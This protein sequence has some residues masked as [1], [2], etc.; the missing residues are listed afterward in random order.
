MLKSD[1]WYIIELDYKLYIIERENGG[2][3]TMRRALTAIALDI[4][5]Q[6]CH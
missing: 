6:S 2:A 4:I 1:V 5:A 3:R